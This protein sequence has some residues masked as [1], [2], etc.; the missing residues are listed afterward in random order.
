M[1]TSLNCINQWGDYINKDPNQNINSKLN[2][3]LDKYNTA[4]S[5]NRVGTEVQRFSKNML[6]KPLSFVT[7][8]KDLDSDRL[9]MSKEDD[10]KL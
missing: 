8:L 1:T 10:K 5:R 4:S 3:F 7:H 6:D 2:S 9:L